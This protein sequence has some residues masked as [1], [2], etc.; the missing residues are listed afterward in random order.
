MADWFELPLDYALDPANRVRRSLMFEGIERQ[1]Y[2]IDWQG[3]RIWG[4]TAA[5]LANLSRR[6]GHDPHS[7]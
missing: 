3:R 5:I 7:S 2:E 1:Y 4:V 6:L